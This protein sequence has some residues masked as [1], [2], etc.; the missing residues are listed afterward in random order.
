MNDTPR[1]Q[2]DPKLTRTRSGAAQRRQMQAAMAAAV[3]ALGS[4]ERR[5]IGWR[6]PLGGLL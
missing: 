1:T 4:Q 2:A 5:R 3:M 6:P